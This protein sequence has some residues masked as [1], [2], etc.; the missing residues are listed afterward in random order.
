MDSALAQFSSPALG[1][2]SKH[3]KPW[4]ANPFNLVS[5]LTML[6]FSAHQFVN[7]GASLKWMEDVRFE[8]GHINQLSLDSLDRFL[9]SLYK[10]L[11]EIDCR[12]SAKLCAF[13]RNGLNVSETPED[14]RA[15]A[16]M[17]RMA[18]FEEMAT[19]QFLWIPSRRARFYERPVDEVLSP[20]AIKRFSEVPRE[21]KRAL[22]C[23]A[24]GEY[25]ASAFHFARACE[26]PLRALAKAVGLT[27][28][29]DSWGQMLRNFE[30]EAARYDPKSPKPPWDTHAEW[31]FSLAADLRSANKAWRNGIMHLDATYDEAQ[32]TYFI[33]A[34][35]KFLN[36]AA[37]RMDE[38]GKLY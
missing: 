5:W 26:A 4:I 6:E 30:N 3:E 21:I 13:V 14:F 29:N 20:E 15:R 23:Y 10:Q 28:K 31:L 1:G 18:I 19:Q 7:I 27:L 11:D 25:T 24:A 16:D 38:T 8:E 35:P 2:D 22:T 33:A 17:L 34:I 9:S 12:I 36:T 32:I 37:S